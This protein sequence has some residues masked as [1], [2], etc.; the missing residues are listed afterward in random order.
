MPKQKEHLRLQLSVLCPT[1]HLAHLGFKS[2]NLG[3]VD[4]T[5]FYDLQSWH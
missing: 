2:V 3:H 1:P 4:V 5:C